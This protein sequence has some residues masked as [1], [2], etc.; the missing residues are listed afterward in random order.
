MPNQLAIEGNVSGGSIVPMDTE[1]GSVLGGRYVPNSRPKPC[2]MTSGVLQSLFLDWNLFSTPSNRL[3]RDPVPPFLRA[4][5]AW[6]SFG[7]SLLTHLTRNRQLLMRSRKGPLSQPG[8]PNL[9]PLHAHSQT[10]ILPVC[11]S[12]CMGPFSAS[13]LRVI[14]AVLCVLPGA[15]S[16]LC[17]NSCR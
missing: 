2:Y 9:F 12:S 7:S 3:T 11:P 4:A 14:Y 8:V 1:Y 15:S 6:L 17:S 10:V 5:Q 13:Y 16:F